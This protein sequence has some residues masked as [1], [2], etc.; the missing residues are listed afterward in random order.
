WMER[1]RAE[2]RDPPALALARLGDQRAVGELARLVADRAQPARVRAEA[3]RLAGALEGYPAKFAL[4][5]TLPGLRPPREGEG[6]DEVCAEAALALG[7]LTDKRAA[8]ALAGLLGQ[9]RY[10]RRAAVMLGRLRDGRAE[11]AL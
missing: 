6:C 5:G 7:E 3:A 8:D 10:R 2:D 9:P 4:R 11:E 1:L